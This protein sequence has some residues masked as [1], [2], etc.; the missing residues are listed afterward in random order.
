MPVAVPVAVRVP[1]VA[2]VLRC[3]RLV[4]HGA[5]VN[6]RMTRR[7]NAGV[8][9]VNMV[10]A[11]PFLM[12]ARAGDAELMRVLVGLGADPLIPNDDGTTPL[13]IAAGVGTHS[14]GEDAGI[15]SDALAA[16]KLA[17]EL[18]GDVNA[19]DKK[20]ETAMHGAA[21]KQLPSVVQFLADH[22]AKVEIWNQKNKSGWTPLRIAE[23]VHR[24]MNFRSSAET[25]AVL[26]KIMSAAGVS[27]VL[28]PEA[29]VSGATR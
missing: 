3:L 14:P 20:G 26:R 24:G 27:T 2:V 19:V 17:W 21:Y 23:G 10:G 1:V 8:T 12:A 22:G 15:E 18:G 16:V 11:T 28:E 9:D 6:A 13:M 4:D 5:N 7:A 25:A 29:V